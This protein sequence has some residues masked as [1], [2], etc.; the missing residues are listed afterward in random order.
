MR[1]IKWLPESVSTMLKR[2]TGRT[3][4]ATDNTGVRPATI[5]TCGPYM[6]SCGT[7]SDATDN[8]CV[9]VRMV[10]GRTLVLSVAPSVR[11]ISLLWWARPCDVGIDQKRVVV[12]SSLLDGSPAALG[13]R[14]CT[15]HI[16]GGYY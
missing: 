12:S 4:G 9:P 3:E 2:L 16:A 1:K 8:S 13:T 10:A 11:P 5:R 15:S 6:Y 14:E 7:D